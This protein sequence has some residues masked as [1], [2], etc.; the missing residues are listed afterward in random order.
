MNAAYIT[1]QIIR[2]N[3]SMVHFS[4]TVSPGVLAPLAILMILRVNCLDRFMNMR[5]TIII[6]LFFIVSYRI[7]SYHIVSLHCNR[8]PWENESY[9]PSRALLLTAS[10]QASMCVLWYMQ[11]STISDSAVCSLFSVERLRYHGPRPSNSTPSMV[12]FLSALSIFATSEK[13][14]G[15]H[16]SH[17]EDSSWLGRMVCATARSSPPACVLATPD[18]HRVTIVWARKNSFLIN[19]IWNGLMTCATSYQVSNGSSMLQTQKKE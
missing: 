7:I 11:C 8:T 1:Q 18:R 15:L 17:R 2:K 10:V 14:G 16:A 4:G 19:V 5:A 12:L 3:N 9:T 6:F 13:E